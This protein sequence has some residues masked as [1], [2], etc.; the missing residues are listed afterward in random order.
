MRGFELLRRHGVELN[1]LCTVNAANQHHPSTSTGSSATSWTQHI[2]LIP[3]VERVTTTPAFRKATRSPIDRSIPSVGAVPDHDLRRMGAARRGHG[4]RARIS[5]PRSHR[6][7]GVQPALCIFGE[8]CGERRGARAQRRPVLLRP[9]RR[10]RLPAR[11]HPR[12]AHGRAAGLTTS[13]DAF[14][15]AKRDTLPAYCRDCSVRFACHGECPKNRFTLTPDGEP[16]LNYLCAGYLAFFT[17]IDGLM[18]MMADLLRR[19][20]LRRRGDGR[21]CAAGRN[22]PCPVRQRSQGEGL[23]RCMM[24]GGTTRRKAE[25]R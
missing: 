11:Q 19:G 2:Q 10:A 25:P 24:L 16:G 6:G 1:V 9:L 12:D 4:V 23:P 5:T 3:I 13:S 18:T 7:S 15:D 21:C 8:T 17:H 22:D 20:P 14:G